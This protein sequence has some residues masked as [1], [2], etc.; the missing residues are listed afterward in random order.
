[1]PLT[2]SENW[3]DD[4][5]GKNGWVRR[6]RVRLAFDGFQVVYVFPALNGSKGYCLTCAEGESWGDISGF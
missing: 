3:V 4:K 1:M 6:D 2:G 5:I